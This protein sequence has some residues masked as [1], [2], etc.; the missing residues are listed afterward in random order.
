MIGEGIS[1]DWREP[2]DDFTLK[3]EAARVGL[4]DNPA[5]PWRAVERFEPI[6]EE[7]FDIPQARAEKLER[8]R[9]LGRE[10]FAALRSTHDPVAM[11]VRHYSWHL[12]HLG[13]P[14]GSPASSLKDMLMVTVLRF[15]GYAEHERGRCFL[16]AEFPEDLPFQSGDR[17]R[18]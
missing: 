1:M 17:G 8:V 11:E 12:M 18:A 14:N 9:S 2:R 3:L 10:L 16:C 6:L 5:D 13:D 4:L 7:L 15:A